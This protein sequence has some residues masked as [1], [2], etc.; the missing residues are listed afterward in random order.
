MTAAD[1]KTT[2][3]DKKQEYRWKYT[4]YLDQAGDTIYITDN[5]RYKYLGVGIGEVFSQMIDYKIPIVKY[6]EYGKTATDLSGNT[7]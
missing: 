5:D 7:V 4:Y 1:C 3:D 6:N 2:Y